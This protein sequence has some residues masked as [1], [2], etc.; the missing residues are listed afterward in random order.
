MMFTGDEILMKGV[1]NPGPGRRSR[2]KLDPAKTPKAIDITLLDGNEQD[3]GRAAACIYALEKGRLMI[4]YPG[5]DAGRPTQFK[6]GDGHG[7]ALFVLERVGP[8]GPVDPGPRDAR[9]AGFEPIQLDYDREKWDYW[10]AMMKAR[11][12][13]EARKVTA[14]KQPKPEPFAERFWKLA[15]ERPNTREEL[16]ALCWAVMNAPASEPGKKALA[17]LENGR[18]AGADVGD[19]SEAIRAGRTDQESLPSP[20]AGLVLQ[21][22]E[23]NLEHPA[24]A[25][26]LTWVC[27]NYWAGDL[28]EEPRTFAEAANLI[29]TRFPD[30]PDIF[31]FCECLVDRQGESRPWAIKYERHLRT[32]LDRNR[33]RWVRCTALY[34]LAAIANGAGADRQDEAAALFESVIKQFGDLSDPRTKNVEKFVVE[35]A[36]RELKAIRDRKAK[37][38]APQ[39]EA[40]R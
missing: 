9:L 21:R 25:E 34:A 18:L 6:T 16:F 1:N 33:G 28:P 36:R 8:K 27:N 29:A 11:T 13:E 39:P 12:P 7:G 5:N 26:L 24:V 4:C 10:N 22:V 37:R 31:N 23:G 2:F 32:I 30:S 3:H 19:L 14:E 35:K 15:Q 38:P 17:V 40:P 20:L